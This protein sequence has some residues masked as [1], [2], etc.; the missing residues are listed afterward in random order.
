MYSM[1]LRQLTPIQKG[2]QSA[3]AVVDYMYARPN[4]EELRQWADIDKTLIVL[5]A[6]TSQDLQDAIQWLKDNN[7]EHSV[8]KEPDLYDMPTAVCFL[9]DERVWDTEAY[10]DYEHYIMDWQKRCDE[11][12]IVRDKDGN[13]T[14]ARY[15]VGHIK[16]GIGAWIADVFGDNVDPKSIINLREFIFSKRLSQ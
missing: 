3:H 11:M 9:A 14:G 16:P 8:F 6:G 1:V 13:D 15:L 4:S 7:I 12:D 2:I 10:P 5:D